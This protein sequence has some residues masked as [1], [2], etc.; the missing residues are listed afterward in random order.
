MQF[1]FSPESHKGNAKHNTAKDGDPCP[2]C[3]T[4]LRMILCARCFGTG[5]SGRHSCK[6]CGGSGV[7]TGCPNFRSHR[8]WPWR[9]RA[10]APA[11]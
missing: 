5:K 7:T 6:A 8:I 2:K 11:A 9:A 4:Q 1:H 10:K 3:G